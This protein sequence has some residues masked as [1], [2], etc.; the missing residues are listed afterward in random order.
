MKNGAV[1]LLDVLG[2]KGIWLRRSDAIEAMLQL[3]ASCR[4]AISSFSG[5]KV[6]GDRFSGLR[7]EV[8]TI[9]DTIAITCHGELDESV[10]LLSYVGNYLIINGIGCHLPL[11]GALSYGLFKSSSNVLLGPAVDEVASW[12]ENS[13]WIGGFLTPSASLKVNIDNFVYPHLLVRHDVPTKNGT[14]KNGLC[15]NWPIVWASE[16]NAVEARDRF[17]SHILNLGPSM[18]EVYSKLS[19][20]IDFYDKNSTPD[21]ENF[22]ELKDRFEDS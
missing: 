9:S 2:W 7:V 10:E 19:N 14:Y 11:R 1:L 12:Y 17:I 3:V 13:E 21:R 15:L 20:T 5:D 8:L 22:S 4:D 6:M 18:P 16:E